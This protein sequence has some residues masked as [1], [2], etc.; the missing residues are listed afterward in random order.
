M[1]LDYMTG[2]LQA[3][4]ILAGTVP[5]SEEVHVRGVGFG[6]VGTGSN[7]NGKTEVEFF[8]QE[9]EKLKDQNDTSQTSTTKR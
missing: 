5:S 4:I 7:H 6:D 8:A 2:I 1:K 9:C 3:S